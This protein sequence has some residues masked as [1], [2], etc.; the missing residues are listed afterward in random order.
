MHS[1]IRL[2]YSYSVLEPY[3][4]TRTME[5]HHG[6][7]QRSLVDKLNATLA[8][9]PALQS[10]SVLE[11]ITRL[12]QIPEEI[13]EAVRHNA[14]GDAC[15]TLYFTGI[16]PNEGGLPRGDLASAIDAT[17][18][19]FQKFQ[20]L[21]SK[22]VENVF[23]CGWVWMSRDQEG[24]LLIETTTACDNPWMFGHTPILAFDVWEH[25]YYLKHQHRRANS[26][27]AWWNVVD[28][29]RAEERFKS[30]K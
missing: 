20:L 27:D 8:N 16:G 3:L 18:G 23:C 10:L 22:A 5:I 28:W 21:F 24:R 14:G 19:S 11:L 12:D 13:R 15:H 4:D 9:Y 6:Q 29:D 7:Y 30:P 1:L 26:V 25:A 2:P 17:F